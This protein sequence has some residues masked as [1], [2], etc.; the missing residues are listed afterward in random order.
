[1]AVI[2]QSVDHRDAGVLCEFL[3][4]LVGEGSNHDAVH[5]AFQVLCHIVHG[6]AL[7]QADF[8][9]TE[10]KRSVLQALCWPTSKVTRV[11]NDGFQKSIASVLP[12]SA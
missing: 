11:R 4:P 9:G 3:N 6:F 1:M 7:A 5:H 10:V 12:L 2:A 8:T